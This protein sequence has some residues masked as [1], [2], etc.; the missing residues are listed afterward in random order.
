MLLLKSQ[1]LEVV[2][3]RQNS[4]TL[5]SDDIPDTENFPERVKGETRDKVAEQIGFGSG[6]RVAD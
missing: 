4:D 1:D 2:K 3:G 5:R 6:S